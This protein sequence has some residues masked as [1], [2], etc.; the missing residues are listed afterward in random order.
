M[1]NARAFFLLQLAFYQATCHLHT[2]TQHC[3]GHFDMLTLQK[4]LG[5]LGKIQNDQGPF[6]FGTAQ[7]DSAIRQFDNFQ[8]RR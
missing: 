1:Q 3:L 6:I 5:V 4:D 2:D 8:K 7:L